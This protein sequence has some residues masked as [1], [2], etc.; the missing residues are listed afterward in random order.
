MIDPIN[1]GRVISIVFFKKK[2][3]NRSRHLMA[4]F[5]SIQEALNTYDQTAREIQTI[6]KSD[7]AQLTNSELSVEKWLENFGQKHEFKERKNQ[8][9]DLEIAQA[10]AELF[11]QYKTDF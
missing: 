1:K 7:L 3:T 8:L 9:V 10:D 4:L 2:E 5:N 11:I 6:L